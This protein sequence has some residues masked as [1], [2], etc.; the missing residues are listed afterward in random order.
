LVADGIKVVTLAAP[1]LELSQRIWMIAFLKSVFRILLEDVL[2]L[3]GP[4]VDGVL[5]NLSFILARSLL[6][7]GNVVW[8][9]RQESPT[10]NLTNGDVGMGLESMESIHQVLRYQVG[11]SDHVEWVSKDWHVN[12]VAHTV[13]V[14]ED[15]LVDLTEDNFLLD[16]FFGKFTVTLEF[17]LGS[18]SDNEKA[19]LLH[20]VRTRWG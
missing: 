14:L 13:E 16:V 7:R 19:L 3:F 10:F 20:L 8:W 4:C 11:P 17:S 2:D 9:E 12:I 1:E 18:S 5:K 6:T 15:W